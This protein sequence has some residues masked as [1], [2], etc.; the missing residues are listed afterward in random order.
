MAGDSETSDEAKVSLLVKTR[1]YVRQRITLVYNKVETQLGELDDQQIKLYI[2]RLNALKPEVADLDRQIFPLLLREE[3]DDSLNSFITENELYEERIFRSLNKLCQ[4]ASY[5]TVDRSR[6]SGFEPASYKLKL[7][8]IQ[9]PKFSNAKGESLEKFFYGFES[10]INKHTLTTYEKYVYL[11]NQLSKAPRVIADSLDTGEQCYELAKELLTKAFGSILTQQYDTIK[12]LSELKLTEGGDPYYFIGEM[13]TI[14][15]S[16]NNLKIDVSTII[17]YFVWNGLNDTF[18]N[19]LVTLTNKNK[20]SL[21]EIKD[22]IFEATERY[23]SRKSSDIKTKTNFRNQYENSYS[24]T[25]GLSNRSTNLALNVKT[26][27]SFI[28]CILCKGDEKQNVDHSLRYCP[29]YNTAGRKVQKLKQ[30]KAC[31]KCSFKNHVT[32]QCRFKFASKCLTCK[33]DHMSYLCMSGRGYDPSNGSVRSVHNRPTVKDST[34]NS[35]SWVHALPSRAEG[36]SILLPTFSCRINESDRHYRCLKDGGCQR[37]FV[38]QTLADELNLPILSQMSLEIHGFNSSKLVETNLVGVSVEINGRIY[39]IE[40]V[41]VPE[42]RIKLSIKNLDKVINQFTNKGYTLADK[43]LHPSTNT[44]ENISM[45]LGADADHVLGMTYNSFGKREP[46]SCYIDTPLG[47]MLTGNVL[48]MIG[49]FR[50]LPC[51]VSPS[52]EKVQLPGPSSAS[53]SSQT[54]ALDRQPVN[55]NE[56]GS[57]R[58]PD[59]VKAENCERQRRLGDRDVK[60]KVIRTEVKLSYSTVRDG[61]LEDVELEQAS[62]KT[63]D[64][65]CMKLLDYDTIE[66][67]EINE[68]NLKLVDY[69]MAKTSRDQNGRLIMPLLWNDK[70]HHLLGR[71]LELSRQI[72]SSNFKKLRKNEEQL[73]MYD[74]VLREQETLGII[75]RIENLEDFVRTHPGVSFL[76]HMGIFKMDRETTKCRVVF[77][78]NLCAGDHINSNPVSHNQAILPGPCLNH[79][80]STSLTLL[81][82]DKYLL[83]FDIA[84]AFLSI[85][86]REC[87]QNRL[88]FL[89]FKNV[90]AGD[91]S[92]IAYKNLMLSFGLRCSPCLLMLALYKILMIDI[93]EDSQ[94][95]LDLKRQVF[96]LMYMD[97]G[98]FTCNDKE[99]L[100][101]A[102]A[103]LPKVFEPY[104][105]LLQQYACNEPGLSSTIASNSDAEKNVEVKL[106]GTV[107]NIESDTL[108]PNSIRLNVHA[109]TKRKILSSLNSVYDVHNVYLPLLNRAKLFLQKLQC[110]SDITW[111]GELSPSLCGE[112]NCIAKQ[113]NA[114]PAVTMKRCV[115]QR[116]DHYSLIAFT[117]SSKSIY[118]IVV[119]IKN[120]RTHEVNFLM[121]RNKLI[122]RQLETKTI[123]ALEFQALCFGVENLNEIYQE[124]SGSSTV[125]PV[126]ID[127][128]ELYTDSMVC[129]HWLK[130]YFH[131][132]G[133][134]QKLSVFVMNR[135]R[136]IDELCRD[137]PVK[138][139]FTKGHVNPADPV[140]RTISYKLLLKTAYW[141]GPSFISSEAYDSN[142]NDIS[143]LVPYPHARLTDEVPEVNFQQS[144]VNALHTEQSFT[145]MEHL[146]PIETYSSFKKLVTVLKYVIKFIN[147]IKLKLKNKKGS[148]SQTCYPSDSNFY[149]IACNLVI[150]T[151]QRLNFPDLITYFEQSKPSSSIPELAGRINLY[152]DSN[153]VIRVKNKLPTSQVF[154]VLLSRD[155]ALTKLI[156]QDIHSSLSH[157]GVY[158]VLKQLRSQFWIRGCFSLVRRLLR[159]CIVCKRLNA[160]PIKLNQSAYR[161]FRLN[162]PSRVFSYIFIDYMGPWL[163]VL[164]SCKVKVWVLVITCLWSR[165]INLK[166]CTSANVDC[167]LRALQ[168]HIYEHGMFQLCVSDLGSQITAGSTKIANFLDD[169]ETHKFLEACG[170]KSVSFD[171]YC[172]GNSSLGSVVESCVK[173]TKS[174][175]SKTIKSIVLNYFDF[176]FVICKTVHLINRRPVAF[177]E[178]L[179]DTDSRCELPIPITPECLMRGGDLVSLNIIPELQPCE[180]NDPDFDK[181]DTGNIK[182]NSFKLGKVNENL[183]DNYNSEFLTQLIHQAT[184]KK[185]RYKPVSHRPLK[186]GDIVLIIEKYLKPSSYPLGIVIDVDLNSLGESTAARVFKGTTRETIYRHATSLILLIPKDEYEQPADMTVLPNGDLSSEC[187]AVAAAPA[188]K[189]GRRAAAVISDSRTRSLKS[190]NLV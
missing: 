189:R 112:W 152:L 154:P 100:E 118:G 132:F 3:S 169:F 65:E 146:I 142:K 52:N 44:I 127:C 137:S 85:G 26:N 117:D 48:R 88:L 17:Q 55:A 121:A 43:L 46:K 79:K 167:F 54:V 53:C 49:N 11:K 109:N 13:R 56:C 20:P 175:I 89:W 51:Y 190:E 57:C 18:K 180:R 16:F 50:H 144:A 38:L 33:G 25:P 91:F 120:M 148:C 23:S 176:E 171:H 174:L 58:V 128:L 119:Y 156:I 179:R 182:V 66:D 166:I 19:E 116:D 155:S 90:K 164:G 145:T 68:T 184:D 188:A 81:R 101:W 9:L 29:I 27:S 45:V 95:L 163:T 24:S 185:E 22:K 92:V 108:R 158:C 93:T 84:R 125:V 104:K 83:T 75:E 97:N 4:L 133:K 94:S 136:R 187:D 5:S 183:I 168:L 99:T 102:Y 103:Q 151:E 35:A 107:W 131:D 178:C 140:S 70:I 123:P 105:F 41:C 10:I 28:V 181:F 36:D 134:M 135:L 162:P 139:H 80:I 76:P 34:S 170:I 126:N 111:D 39:E 2:E 157:G 40:A 129:L 143:L 86:L 173:Q 160:R 114:V 153:A 82:F 159:E 60:T 77:L 138:F 73:T 37:N 87:D 124:L 31:T 177:K 149:N 150:S 96:N 165:A 72:L 8:E 59:S 64:D 62:V 21:E 122:G 69:V 7:P 78:S 141:R 161:D 115:G 32:S 63:L 12:M 147:N 47:V 15:A 42:I 130:S 113:M 186:K 1:Q 67:Y 71:N 110:N 30:L 98:G 6:V 14:C 74:E 172:K 61:K 106:L